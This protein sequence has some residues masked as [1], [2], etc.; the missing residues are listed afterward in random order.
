MAKTPSLE[1]RVAAIERRN[2]RVEGDKAWERSWARRALIALL[3]FIVVFAFLS[4]I[5]FQNPWLPALVP[6]VGYLLSTLGLSFFK[7]RW[8]QNRRG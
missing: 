1:S 8:L 2:A 5:D 6:A 3:T 4:I 7:E